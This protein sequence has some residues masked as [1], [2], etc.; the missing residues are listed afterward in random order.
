MI[1]EPVQLIDFSKLDECIND[2]YYPYLYDEKRFNVFYGGSAS[3]KSVFVAQRAVYR[4]ITEPGHNYMIVRKSEK[5]NRF[6]SFALIKQVINDWG[7][8]AQF[9][10][11]DYTMELTSE[12]N[13]NQ[14]VFRGLD[15]IEKLKSITFESG[16]L[17][18]IW[19]EEASEITKDDDYQLRLRLRGMAPV[20]KQ[21][22]YTFNP[23]SALHW[24]KTRFFDNPLPGDKCSVVKSTYKDNQWLPSEDA[25]QIESLKHE[26]EQFYKIYALGEWG[27]LGDHV[28]TNWEC[29]DFNVDE[30]LPLADT[31]YFGED[32]GYNNPSVCLLIA[33]FDRE[34]YICNELYQT[35]LTNTQLIDQIILL[36]PDTWNKYPHYPDSAE[37]DRIEEM[38][39]A[40]M[41]VRKSDKDIKS[42]IDELRRRKI[43]IHQKNCPFTYKE[44]QAYSY[45][46]DSNGNVLDSPIDFNDHAM[47]ATRYGV[48]TNS[49]HG[50]VQL[51]V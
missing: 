15:D 43:I 35:K 28:L 36:F 5:A 27:V 23:I 1:A 10:I 25:E 33:E 26:D 3:G 9:Y 18:D 51:F 30:F 2:I 14:M 34:V 44:I 21:I 31:V 17:T 42:G 50:G 11:R 40:G 13:G 29:R 48:Y 24:L 45:K 16:A 38:R 37:P 39:Q 46:K 47:D 22:T 49:K 7:L 12:V 8:G 20:Q 32:F 6:S 19:I 41:D 4:M